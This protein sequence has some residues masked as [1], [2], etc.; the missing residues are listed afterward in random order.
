MATSGLANFGVDTEIVDIFTEA[1]ERCGID[2]TKL[3]GNWA[4]SARR[5]LNFL[6]SDWSNTGPNLWLVQQLRFRLEEDK[7]SY[8]LP[9]NTVS[10][11][12]AIVR[13]DD[14]SPVQDTILSAISRAEYAAIPNKFQDAQRPTQYYLERTVPPVVHF[15]PPPNNEDFVFLYWAMTM[16]SDVGA[17]SNTF[18]APS[19]W[20]EA[21]AS[22]LA[23]KL[24]QKWAIDR[25]DGLV[26]AANTAYARAAAEDTESVPLRITIDRQ[27]Y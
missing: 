21:I 11:V 26:A 12:N 16:A 6:A 24:A 5:S 18:D 10:I 7:I 14:V 22:G 2:G 17:L 15:W 4:D 19:R 1:Y 3:P 8:T 27:D 13:Q 23:A 9:T 20:M 25:Y